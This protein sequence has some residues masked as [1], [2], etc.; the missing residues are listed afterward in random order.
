MN[1]LFK[2]NG[3]FLVALALI[4]CLVLTAQAQESVVPEPPQPGRALV[5]QAPYRE[6]QILHQET[7]VDGTTNTVISLPAIADA[8]IASARPDENFGADALYLGYN[9]SGQNEYGAQRL[10]LHFDV[11][12]YVP[13][14]AVINAAALQL[15]LSFSS[16]ADDVPMGTVLRR[17]A[18]P[19]NEYGVTW[20]DEPEWTPI[21]TTADVGSAL[22]WYE[23]DVTDL[24]TNWAHD[25]YA[26][27]G[28]EIIGD[29]TVQERER[30]FYSRETTSDNYPR[31]VID[32]TDTGD[33]MPPIVTV[34]ALPEYS[35]RDFTVSWQGSDQ[36]SAG[37]DYYDVQVRIDGGDWTDWQMGTTATSADYV[38]AENGRFYE[39]RARGVDNAGNVEPFGGPEASTTA[40]TQPPVTTVDPLPVLVHSDNITVSWIGSDDVSGIQYYDVRWKIGNGPWNLWQQETLA[41]SFNLTGLADNL[42]QFEARAVDNL[43]HAEPFTGKAEASVI[44]DANPPFVEPAVWL[45]MIQK[46]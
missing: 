24:V 37:L 20:N 38:G 42:Y 10:L 26:N 7:A 36:G 45:P 30:A 39:F 5:R 2:K 27:H 41:T 6:P 29:E 43:G 1:I 9:L 12:T 34:D 28:L 25:T 14:G 8:Y 19:W 33:T 22:A 44:I 23:W 13:A 35:S 46:P 40:D 11:D 4:F 3:R 31:L 16:P 18:S 17:L 15:R 21:D 32:Y